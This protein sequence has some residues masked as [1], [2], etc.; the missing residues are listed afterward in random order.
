[1]KKYVFLLTL[2]LLFVSDMAY[3]RFKSQIDIKYEDYYRFPLANGDREIVNCLNDFACRLFV[4]ESKS[5]TGNFITSPL[6]VAG[7]LV[8]LS[9]VVDRECADEIIETLGISDT[10]FGKIQLQYLCKYLTEIGWYAD[11]KTLCNNAS[12]IWMSNR[13]K[14][15]DVIKFKN[16]RWIYTSDFKFVNF[17]NKSSVASINQ[18]LDLAFHG[19][20]AIDYNVLFPQDTEILLQGASIFDG[21]FRVQLQDSVTNGKFKPENGNSHKVRMFN[22]ECVYGYSGKEFENF[23]HVEY[24]LGNQAFRLCLILPKPDVKLTACRTFFLRGMIEFK[25]LSGKPIRYTN[26][27]FPEKITISQHTDYTGIIK[28]LGVKKI[29]EQRDIF[30]HDSGKKCAISAV[31]QNSIFRL[32][33]IYG[34]DYRLEW[35][36]GGKTEKTPLHFDRPFMFYIKEQSTGLIYF[37]GEVRDL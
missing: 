33:G 9:E 8:A 13:L 19:L 37:I 25:M 6:G 5:A 12:S 30:G 7:G 10:R 16:S 27:L 34:S 29:F 4:E 35:P 14:L 23:Y 3:G 28:Q 22:N 36:L 15:E 17:G 11:V 21:I 1:M 20:P 26:L 18:W 31:M 32:G 24:P 2:C